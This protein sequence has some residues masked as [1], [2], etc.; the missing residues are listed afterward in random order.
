ME[1]IVGQILEITCPK[2]GV[3]WMAE[4]NP[5]PWHQYVKKEDE[6]TIFYAELE[7]YYCKP[8]LGCGYT[9]PLGKE[10]D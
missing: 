6:E 10:D 3:V 2:C 8:P 4:M 7:A 5:M 1:V 9:I